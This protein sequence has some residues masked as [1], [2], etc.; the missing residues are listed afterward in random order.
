MCKKANGTIFRE[1]MERILMIA[2]VDHMR[3][4]ELREIL[5]KAGGCVTFPHIHHTKVDKDIRPVL[6]SS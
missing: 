4:S 1:C 6:D 5:K 3:Q 2:K